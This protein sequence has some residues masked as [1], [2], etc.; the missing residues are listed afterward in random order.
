M[1][2]KECPYFKPTSKKSCTYKYHTNGHSK[3]SSK[4]IFH[5]NIN[6]C[7]VFQD[8]LR[9]QKCMDEIKKSDSRAL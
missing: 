1:K 2:I 3:H 5:N 8:W 4:C 6:K 9:M 7:P